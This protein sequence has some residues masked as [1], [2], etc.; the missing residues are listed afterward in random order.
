MWATGLQRRRAGGRPGARGA[1][2][3][4]GG[5][6][7][8]VLRRGVVEPAVGAVV[9]AGSMPAEPVFELGAQAA[10]W[11]I[12]GRQWGIGRAGGVGDPWR[13]TWRPGGRP[14][15]ESHGGAAAWRSSWWSAAG[16]R[17]AMGGSAGTPSGSQA[18]LGGAGQGIGV[19]G[20]ADHVA[21]LLAAFLAAPGFR[22]EGGG[23]TRVLSRSIRSNRRSAPSGIGPRLPGDAAAAIMASWGSS[24]PRRR[25]YTLTATWAKATVIK[26]FT[27]VNLR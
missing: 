10:L 24:G 14:V 26:A 7:V 3:R 9:A 1:G 19:E 5:R 21:G 15:A 17:A 13:G 8:A 18:G 23:V 12:A 25:F 2:G 22:A 11:A 20:A 4:P 6:P 16:C 27:E